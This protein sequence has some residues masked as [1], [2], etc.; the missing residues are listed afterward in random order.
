MPRTS[1]CARPRLSSIAWVVRPKVLKR[2]RAPWDIGLARTRDV[3]GDR[4]AAGQRGPERF[5]QLQRGADAVAEQQRRAGGSALADRHPEAEPVDGEEANLIEFFAGG[6]R[7]CYWTVT[8]RDV[9]SA[10]IDPH[11]VAAAALLPDGPSTANR[12]V[13]PTGNH[14][15]VRGIPLAQ[16]RPSAQTRRHQRVRGRRCA[17]G[18]LDE[19]ETFGSTRSTPWNPDPD[20]FALGA[21]LV[22]VRRTYEH[23]ALY[24]GDGMLL[25]YTD[26]GGVRESRRSRRYRG[27]AG[28]GSP[29]TT[30]AATPRCSPVPRR[31]SAPGG[32]P[33][34]CSTAVART[35]AST[36]STGR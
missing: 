13:Q 22:F 30:T 28:T 29:P 33:A 10:S 18:V 15:N 23:H 21:H 26:T 11:R 32:G 8:W 31:S 7:P 27:P 1:T 16:E 9:A 24:A 36:W 34:R 19:L 6:T 35:T 20:R 25:E 17:A 3:E 12:S 5:E 2:G 4:G 14:P